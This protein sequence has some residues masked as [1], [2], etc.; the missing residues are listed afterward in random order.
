MNIEQYRRVQAIAKEVHNELRDFISPYSTESSISKSAMD[1]LKEKGVT[2]TWYHN[3]PA[4]VI[5]GSRSC[6]SISGRDYLPSREFVGEYNLITVDLSPM[7]GDVWGDCARSYYVEDGVCSL[8]PISKEFSDGHDVQRFLHKKMKEFLTPDT[9]FSELYEFGNN[10]IQESGF[11]NLDF[12]GNL[13]HSI[14]VEPSKR[15]FIDKDCS[16]E[17]GCVKF[18]TFEPHIK[19]IGGK[20]GFKHENIYYFDENGAPCEL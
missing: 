13:G 11:K 20:W 16:Q 2:D 1:L 18:F 8:N 17:I 15:R 5:L 9:K 14:E 6:L 3:V 10:L 7:I 19:L 4:F 12:L